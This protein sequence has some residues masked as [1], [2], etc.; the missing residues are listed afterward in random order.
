MS[1][2]WL[3]ARSP[4]EQ[5][6]I[7]AAA[8]LVA[9]FALYY[10]AIAPIAQFHGAAR[11]DYLF[12]R[13]TLAEVERGLRIAEPGGRGGSAARLSRREFSQ[14]INA[15]ARERALAI[16]RMEPDAEG[17]LRVWFERAEAPA[18]FALIA[19]LVDRHGVRIDSAVIE[20]N[21]D[22]ATVSARFVLAAGG[23][24]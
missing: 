9:G 5:I 12:A 20:Q 14:T 17:G 21:D 18:L 22:S 13:Q 1:F 7:A 2:D 3:Q 8:F 6:L 4:R 15:L 19:D 24:Q 11:R 16:V 23:A 10:L